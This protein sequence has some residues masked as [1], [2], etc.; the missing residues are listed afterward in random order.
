MK[1]NGLKFHRIGR[2]TDF[3]LSSAWTTGVTKPS[4]A[5]LLFLLDA[6]KCDM[7]KATESEPAVSKI[8]KQINDRV[9]RPD[10]W[11]DV[12]EQSVINHVARSKELANLEAV[13]FLAREPMT[14]RRLAQLADLPEGSKPK[15]MLRE[16]NEF[17]DRQHSAFRIIE[18]AGGFQ[19]RTRPEFAPWLVR[20]QEVPSTVRLSTPAMETLAVIAYRQPVLR[21]DIERLRGVQCGELI[22]Q[23]LDR[24]LVRIV[25]R[26]E[27]LG[28]P[29]YYGT[30]RNFLEVFGLSG[31]KD[32]PNRDLFEADHSSESG[33]LIHP[34]ISSERDKATVDA[35]DIATHFIGEDTKND[36][37]FE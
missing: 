15:S 18:V 5:T 24:D 27:E 37:F 14:V 16:L 1:N 32:L 31:L 10:V 17:Y 22:R 21:A 26:S 7:D 13:L 6:L 19:L 34:E 36:D 28:R 2:K 9:S 3:S 4:V 23:L 11:T 20:M 12:A 35:M 25:G 33:L 29:F 30:T 8:D